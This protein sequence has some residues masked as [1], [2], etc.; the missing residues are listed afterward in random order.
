MIIK[1]M[2]D[3]DGAKLLCGNSLDTITD[4]C[5]DTRKLNEGDTY[6]GLKGENFDGNSFYLEALEKGA[7]T[8][9]VSGINIPIEVIN[10]YSNRNIIVVNDT[11]KFIVQVGKKKRESIN[12]PIIAVTGSVGKT[13][14]RNI[15]ASVLES[16]YRVL[17]SNDN[18][19]T[20][21][22][23]AMT[24]LRYTNEEI[25]VVEMAMNHL[26]EIHEL[27][28]FVRPTVAIITNIGTAHIGNLGSRENILKAKLEILDGLN[29]PIIVNYDNDL[30]KKW[31]EDNKNNYSIITY[32]IDFESNYQAKNISYNEHG[33]DFYLNNSKVNINVI[34]KH[35][36]YNSLAAFIIADIYHINYED[37]IIKLKNIPLEKNRME[38]MNTKGYTIIND[39]YNASYDSIYYALEVLSSFKRRKIA[40][41][42][43]ILEL[44]EYSREIHENI[45]KLVSK[46]KID[47]LITVG[48]NAELINKEAIKLGL[49]EANTYHFNNNEQAIIF[50]KNN[51]KSND[52]I[53][54]KASNGMHFIEIVDALK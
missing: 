19:N 5:K 39:T 45:G 2:L 13:S 6:L 50:L 47:I 25:I 51:I 40:V 12:V 43:D 20:M 49:N 35:F 29:G 28:L 7:K 3:I 34:G 32:S 11:A 37:V 38:L 41:L 24:F 8:I 1:D 14:T 10:K 23:L 48:E 36:I 46:N 54:I 42:G 22:G 30:L 26:G 33:S 44:G 15:I 27:S 16:K 18:L 9:I 21:I 52:V 4:I 17:K 53:L 31:A